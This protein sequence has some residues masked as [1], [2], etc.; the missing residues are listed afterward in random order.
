MD[1]DRR[2]GAQSLALAVT[3]FSSKADYQRVVDYF[4]CADESFLRGMGVDADRLP[5]RH[6]W[7]ERLLPDLTLPD[8]QKQTFYVGRDYQGQRVGH[9][10]LNQLV[11]GVQAYAHLHLWD[12]ATRRGGLALS[13]S[14]NP[15]GCSS[16]GSPCRD[17]TASLM[18]IIRGRI[19]S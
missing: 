17:C 12:R 19:A 2:C 11:Y 4:L 18:P 16:N 3:P 14:G 15:S 6:A 7:L 13:S 10:N 8:S 9:C 1:P 5:D